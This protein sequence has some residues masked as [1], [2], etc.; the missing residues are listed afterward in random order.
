[1]SDSKD[2]IYELL[3]QLVE[4]KYPPTPPTSYLPLPIKLPTAK[5]LKSPLS[6][7]WNPSLMAVIRHRLNKEE[8]TGLRKIRDIQKGLTMPN[9]EQVVIGSAKKMVASV[10]FFDLM[11]FT[12]KSAELGNENTLFILNLIIPQ[13]MHIIKHWNGEIE[14]NTGDGIMAIFGT[15]TR[16]NFLIARDTIEAAMSIRYLMV[17]EINP[18]LYRKGINTF[19]FRVGI[20]ME[21]LLI[22][23][24]GIQGTNFLSV[25]GSAANRASKLQGYAKSDGICIG[26]NFYRSL[27]PKLHSYCEQGF[28]KEWNWIYPNTKQP[29]RFF[30]FNANWPEP[31]EWLKIKF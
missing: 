18:M 2:N 16:N 31:K 27:H 1:M 8:K 11:D 24:V 21:E 12:L 7:K 28:H 5:D 13:V 10:M 30:H 22:A 6:K 15:E 17:N 9:I 14:K 26:E 19:G 4:Q 25:V 29:Y 20:D 23:R 3:R